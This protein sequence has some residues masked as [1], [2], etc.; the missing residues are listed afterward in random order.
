MLDSYT[1]IIM[2]PIAI[3]IVIGIMLFLKAV[4]NTKDKYKPK[5]IKK[6]IDELEKK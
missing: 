5:N 3:I 4:T 2:V 1:Y 6:K